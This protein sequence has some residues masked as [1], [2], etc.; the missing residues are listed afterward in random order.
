MLNIK[1][2][3]FQVGPMEKVPQSRLIHNGQSQDAK[4]LHS[5]QSFQNVAMLYITGKVI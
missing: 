3:T 1:Q 2:L 4:N 5:I